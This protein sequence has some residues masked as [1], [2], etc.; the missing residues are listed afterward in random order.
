MGSM[1]EVIT[2]EVKTSSSQKT[3]LSSERFQI[4]DKLDKEL[5]HDSHL[6]YFTT[7]NFI[8]VY[9]D[10]PEIYKSFSG[11]LDTDP[12]SLGMYLEDKLG[13]VQR[14]FGI[15]DLKGFEVVQVKKGGIFNFFMGGSHSGGRR[16]QIDIDDPYEEARFSHV[17]SRGKGKRSP[18]P[19]IYS[20]AV[21]E[22]IGHG[23]INTTLMEGK[24]PDRRMGFVEEGLASYISD[25]AGSISSHDVLVE[26]MIEGANWVFPQNLRNFE[27]SEE[28]LKK[29]M[30]KTG[31]MNNIPLADLF[32]LKS[33]SFQADKNR[34]SMAGSLPNY[35][36]GA[37]FIKYV[38]DAFGIDKFKKWLNRINKIN[39]Y[40]GLREVY[41]VEID[42]LEEGW[43][44]AVLRN[45]F[46]DN[47]FIKSN[48]FQQSDDELEWIRSLYD[49]YS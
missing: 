44:N 15:H 9:R 45:S 25:I 21:H 7:T 43:K 16:T 20:T 18:E 29:K 41:G 13:V 33:T 23:F 35:A 49:R 34:K 40:D 38:I 27:L 22:A 1:A 24:N 36:R 6:A 2:P 11:W 46:K 8:V 5:E 30:R 31:F 28:D 47:P 48:K 26:T 32:K 42:E 17:F 4:V 12:S 19:S 10:I 39:F 37:S 14:H 3:D